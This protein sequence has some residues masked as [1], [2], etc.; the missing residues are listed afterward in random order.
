MSTYP[1]VPDPSPSPAPAPKKGPAAKPS[2]VEKPLWPVPD[3]EGGRRWLAI[4]VFLAVIGLYAWGISFF[5]AGAHAGVDQNGYLMTARLIAGDRNAFS[6]TAPA[7]PTTT[8]PAGSTGEHPAPSFIQQASAFDWIRN[9]LSFVPDTPF[10]FAGRMDIITEP[11]GPASPDKPA[12][13]RVYAKYPFGYPLMAAIGRLIGGINGMYVI[14]PLCAVLAC[15]FAYFLF[16]QAV[17]PF[18]SLLGVIWLA[19]NPLVLYYANDANSHA[20]TLF[21]VTAGFWGVVSW[22]R[23]GGKQNWRAWIGG[24]ALG[25]ACTIRYS[26]FL[27]VLPV[28]FAALLNFRWNWKRAWGSLSLLLAWSIPVAVLAGVCWVCFGAPWKTGYTYCREST[29]FAWKYLSGDFGEGVVRQGNWETMVTQ[30]NHTGL[31][32]LWPLAIAGLFAMLGSAWR[33]G[34]LLAL[35]VLP[36]TLLYML[37]YWA[38]GGETTVGYMRFFMSIVPGLIFGGIW[39]L[40]RGLAVLKGETRASLAAITAFGLFFFLCAALYFENEPIQLGMP[41]ITGTAAAIRDFAWGSRFGMG[42]TA[43]ILVTLAGIWIFDRPYA[44]A[45]TGIALGAGV[46]TAIGCGINLHNILPQVDANFTQFVGLRQTVDNVLAHAPRGTVIFSDDRLLN[47]LD[48]VGGWKLIN[49]T[50]FNP[51]TFAD[52]KRRVD[53]RERDKEKQDD[54]DPIQVERSRFYEE[55]LGVKDKSGN[56][57]QKPRSEITREK[58]DLI[59]KSLAEGRRVMFLRQEGATWGRVDVPSSGNGYNVKVIARSDVPDLQA[60]GNVQNFA[61]RRAN[62]APPAGSPPPRH[63]TMVYLWEIVK[64]SPPAT[65]PATTSPATTGKSPTAAPGE[66]SRKASSTTK[67]A[68]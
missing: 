8:Q 43:F 49:D 57:N 37:Y 53:N 54:P 20:S 51:A 38:P 66:P 13:Y 4:M 56:W 3:E 60:V 63:P 19:C 21:C 6:P 62:I 55:L 26:E 14:N 12:E 30:L 17:T 47:E 36:S 50:F 11:F 61:R 35:W 39:L 9:R 23:L 18:M 15:Y 42:M 34:M 48:A 46:L 29:G 33:L 44:A 31:F 64:A 40:D 45:R 2:L 28:L 22:L 7:A 52:S 16:R 59:A 1:L 65:R 24:L 68:R 41:L 27:L 5:Y 10:Q 67:A 58:M 32:V 25:Y